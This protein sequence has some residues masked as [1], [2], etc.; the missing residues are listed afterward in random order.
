MKRSAVFLDRDGVINRSMIR[1]GKPYPPASVQEL[2]ILPGVKQALEALRK[3]GFLLVV[4]T[5]QPDVARGT[6]SKDSIDRIHNYL[7][8]EL[9][10]DAVLTCF[11][12]DADKCDCR[13]PK[14]GLMVRA[15]KEMSIDLSASYMVGDRWRD[16][17]AGQQAGCRNFF[18]DYGYDEK[19]PQSYDF[20]VSSLLE[21]SQIILQKDKS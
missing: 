4:V 19:Q 18:V 3:A 13:K 10:L 11:H 7:K 8:A 1:A 12:D 2:E 21:A 17:E 14:P 20:R 5:N 16:I 15:A 9:P 6:T